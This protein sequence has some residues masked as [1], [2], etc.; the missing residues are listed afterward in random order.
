M[1]WSVFAEAQLAEFPLEKK[2]RLNKSSSSRINAPVPVS[3]PFWDDF[4]FATQGH[5]V[6]SLW[7]NN[8]KVIVNSGQAVNIPTLNVA[9]FDG[10][11]QNGI[12]YSPSPTD[13]LDFGYR[14][15]LESQPIKMTEVSVPFR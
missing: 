6:D 5:A 10:L 3:L 13:N 15:T 8:N 9:T 14:D 4:S 7:I 1:A 11:D 12:P 2:S